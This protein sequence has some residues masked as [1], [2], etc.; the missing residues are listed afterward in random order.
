MQIERYHT[1]REPLWNEFAQRSKNG[2]FLFHRSYMEYHADR[3]ED[4]S[5]RARRR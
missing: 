5:H 3:F 1:Q 4:F 2:T